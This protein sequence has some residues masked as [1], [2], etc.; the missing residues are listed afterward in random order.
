MHRS[1]CDKPKHAQPPLSPT[2]GTD[3]FDHDAPR[4]YK[5]KKHATVRNAAQIIAIRPS[6]AT[7]SIYNL[8]P[9]SFPIKKA[10]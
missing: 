5:A 6:E 4:S 9:V 8:V 10:D 1:L 2:N 3:E 7:S